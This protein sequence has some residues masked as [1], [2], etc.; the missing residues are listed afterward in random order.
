M[1]R[2]RNS[3][4]EHG[5][6]SVTIGAGAPTGEPDEVRFTPGPGSGPVVA[7]EDCFVVLAEGEG[8]ARTM[9]LYTNG[10]AHRP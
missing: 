6:K 9:T 2:V 4:E 3:T 8:G 7:E 10:R 1:V 5:R